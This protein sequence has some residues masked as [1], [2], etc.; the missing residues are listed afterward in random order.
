M[1]YVEILRARRV[2][3][4]FCGLLLGAFVLVVIS[5]YSGHAH[6]HGSVGTIHLSELLKGCAFGAMVL[7]TC[8]APGLNAE[9]GTLAIAWTRPASRSAIAWRYIAVDVVTILVGYAFVVAL[10]LGFLAVY[11]LLG[12]LVFDAA[13]P[14]ALLNA[15]G[16][17]LMWYGLVTVVAAR[18]DGRAGLIAG[19]SWGVFLALT[20]LWIAPLPALLHGLITFL[21]YFNP[22]AYFADASSDQA[23]GRTMVP[24]TA[25]YLTLIAWAFVAVTLPATVRLWSTREV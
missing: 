19:V 2:L 10:V 22:F 24:L 8:V 18:M 25:G 7:A 15:V 1:Q 14:V 11:G 6:M 4:W 5:A 13:V 16:C 20:L 12:N 3:T 21:N 17:T 23:S 9:S